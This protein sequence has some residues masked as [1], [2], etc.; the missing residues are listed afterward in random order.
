MGVTPLGGSVLTDEHLRL[1]WNSGIELPG[2]KPI[3]EMT[4]SSFVQ[5]KI[6][7]KPSKK[8]SQ[9]ISPIFTS[10]VRNGGKLRIF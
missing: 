6:Q 3:L 2:R 8:Q 10:L 4:T 9:L 5:S 1:V 7:F